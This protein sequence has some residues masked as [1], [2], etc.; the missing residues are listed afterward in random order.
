MS[1]SRLVL[2]ALLGPPFLVGASLC[3]LAAALAQ[4]GRWNPTWDLFTHFAVVYLAVGV[5]TALMAFIFAGRLRAAVAV[6][7]LACIF[8]A[9]L[10]MAPEYL[11]ST[12]PRAAA[13]AGPAFRV[14]QFNAWSG[15]NGEGRLLAWLKVEKP[16]VLVVEEANSRVL[17]ALSSAGWW[18]V[19][20]RSGVMLFTPRR[21][22]A[23]IIPEDNPTGPMEL[24]GVVVAS[25]A[26]PVTVLGVHAPWPSHPTLKRDHDLLLP[27]VRSYPAAT[28]I[29]AGDFNSTPWSFARQR[30]DRDLGLIRRTRAVFT[31]PIAAYRRPLI[32]VLPIDHVYAGSGWATV[33]VERGPY[34]GSDH[35]PVAV[36][37]A[38]IARP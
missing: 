10:L 21:P 9:G 7:G 16:D 20:G 35:F 15:R 8:A 24:N 32:P 4:L 22:L 25:A 13:G 31:W 11:R 18:S 37:L 38:P 27:I 33:K 6:A 30:D 29:L 17:N 5:I 34:L 12:G 19:A 36:T 3:A 1:S 14:I 26:G 2:T 23:A 28:T